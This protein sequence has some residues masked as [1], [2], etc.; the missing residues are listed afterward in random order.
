[1]LKH[2]TEETRDSKICTISKGGIP[3]EYKTTA[4]Y[5]RPRSKYQHHRE[6]PDYPYRCHRLLAPPGPPIGQTPSSLVWNSMTSVTPEC[7]LMADSWISS[8][9]PWTWPGICR[10]T[11]SPGN[12]M[13]YRSL[14]HMGSNHVTVSLGSCYPWGR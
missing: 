8:F 10:W 4:S 9:H 5:Y 13:F 7:I 3:V 1:M 11:S 2:T 14:S 6:L 12:C